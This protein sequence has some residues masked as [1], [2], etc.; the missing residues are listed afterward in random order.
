MS[1]ICQA[2]SLIYQCLRHLIAVLC[3]CVFTLLCIL[4]K[5]YAYFDDFYLKIKIA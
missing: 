3:F 4:K 1:S 2:V 5:P